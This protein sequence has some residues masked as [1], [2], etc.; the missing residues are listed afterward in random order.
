MREGGGKKLWIYAILATNLGLLVG[1]RTCLGKVTIA[2]A[3]RSAAIWV[4]GLS[5]V[6]PRRDCERLGV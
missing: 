4:D 2:A 3:G 5:L 1:T 6:Q